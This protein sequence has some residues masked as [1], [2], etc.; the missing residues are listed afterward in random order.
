MSDASHRDSS[1][2]AADLSALVDHWVV[3]ADVSPRH[4]EL[5]PVGGPV[6]AWLFRGA[7]GALAAAVRCAVLDL[8]D[9]APVT[10]GEPLVDVPDSP[11][12]DPELVLVGDELTS[13]RPL[14]DAHRVA[15]GLPARH[16]TITSQPPKTAR[17]NDPDLH[18]T[19][20]RRLDQIGEWTKAESAYREAVIRS[21]GEPYYLVHLA[22]F[23]AEHGQVVEAIATF[24]RARD[25][26]LLSFDPFDL[27][28]PTRKLLGAIEV[29]LAETLLDFG[30]PKADLHRREAEVLLGNWRDDPALADEVVRLV[31]RHRIGHDDDA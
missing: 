31:T 3:I 24:R 19:L 20:A 17:A 21:G 25:I 28:T 16:P 7:D 27:A 1:T 8:G 5:L 14:P 15:L 12:F 30:G 4:R 22:A 2:A 11:L 29:G 13:A 18:L 10:L 23:L 9:E 6:V 26:V